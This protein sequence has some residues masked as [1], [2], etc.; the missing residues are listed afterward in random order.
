MAEE[1]VSVFEKGRYYPAQ[2]AGGAHEWELSAGFDTEEERGQ[3]L[4]EVRTAVRDY[5]YRK[6]L[7]W[8]ISSQNGRRRPETRGRSFRG[9]ISSPRLLGSCRSM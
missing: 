3:F 2:M 6:V 5:W 4:R 7:G 8:A 9:R 1:G